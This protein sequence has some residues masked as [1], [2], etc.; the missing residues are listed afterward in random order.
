MSLENKLPQLITNSTE[1]GLFKETYDLYKLGAEVSKLQKALDDYVL[2]RFSY[3]TF[4]N[5][6]DKELNNNLHQMQ[7]YMLSLQRK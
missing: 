1:K 3:Q 5:L 6:S 4:Y 2:E 7:L